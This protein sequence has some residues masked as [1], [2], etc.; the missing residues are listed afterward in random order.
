MSER[1]SRGWRIG[2]DTSATAETRGRVIWDSPRPPAPQPRWSAADRSPLELALTGPSYTLGAPQEV[3]ER[4]ASLRSA[5]CP[6][7]SRTCRA[8]CR[9]TRSRGS[10]RASPGASR[11]RGARLTVLARQL[12]IGQQHIHHCGLGEPDSLYGGECST[13]LNLS[14]G[15]EEFID[16]FQELRTLSKRCSVTAVTAISRSLVGV[17]RGFA[18]GERLGKPFVLRVFEDWHESCFSLIHLRVRAPRRNPAAVGRLRMAAPGAAS[19]ERRA[20]RQA[21][22]VNSLYAEEPSASIRLTGH[23]L[24]KISAHRE[25]PTPE[26]ALVECSEKLRNFLAGQR[27]TGTPFSTP[28]RPRA[29]GSPSL[30]LK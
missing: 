14:T 21:N 15:L 17:D 12:A 3:T 23:M 24:P 1:G 20:I 30:C 29:P 7:S 9:S 27:A 4:G 26:G 16:A 22:K 25:E 28:I 19:S 6:F 10:R 11:R 13:P 2:L 8:R 18:G 5:C